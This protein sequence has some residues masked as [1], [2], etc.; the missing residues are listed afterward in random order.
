MTDLFQNVLTASFHGSIVI[1][2]VLLLRFLL[3]RTPKKFLC[4]LWLLVG[5][6]LLMPFEIQS[7]LS[8]QPDMGAIRE[9]GIVEAVPEEFYLDDMPVFLPEEPAF[10]E[11]EPQFVNSVA[12]PEDGAFAEEITAGEIRDN[13]GTS[14][15]VLDAVAANIWLAVAFGFGLYTFASYLKLRWKV[16]EAVRLKGNVWECDRIETAFILGFIRPRIYLPMG[17]SRNNRRHILAHERTHLEKG[18]HWIKMIGYAALAIHWFNPLVWVA[19]ILLCKDIEMACDE[20]VVQFMELEER[21]SYSAALINCSTNHAHFGAC[22]VAFGEVSVKNRVMTVLKYK[23]PSFWIS[24]A[25]VIAIIFVAVCLVTSPTEE[26]AV[27]DSTEPTGATEKALEET[28]DAVK[29]VENAFAAILAQDRYHLFFS[30]ETSD[31]SVGWQVNMYKDGENTLWSCTDH[32]TREGHMVLD[33]VHYKFIDGA[34]GG[35]VPYEEE[36]TMLQE[37]LAHFDLEGRDIQNVASHLNTRED[38]YT[39][40]SLTF[41]AYT[42]GGGTMPTSQPMTVY[43]DTEGSMTGMRVENPDRKGADIFSFSNWS[44]ENADINNIDDVFRNAR[45]NLLSAEDV[46]PSKLQPLTQDEQKMKEWGITF[47]VDDDVLTRNGGESWFAQASGYNMPVYTDNEYWLEKQTDTGWEKLEMLTQPKWEEASYTLNHDRY[48]VVKVDWTMLYGPLISGKY[49]MGKTFTM[50]DAVTSCIG[51]A[52]FDIYYNESNSADQKAAVERC[53]AGLEEL[54]QRD[55]IHY[56]ATSESFSTTEVWWNDGDYLCEGK[57]F[58]TGATGVVQGA[59]GQIQPR[60]DTMVRVDGVGYHEAR[61]NPDDLSSK[62]IG[63]ELS[64]FSPNRAGWEL[65][66]FTECLELMFFE[67]S[68]KTIT[69][70]DGIGVVSDEMVRFKQ[71]WPVQG[72]EV[73]E[74]SAQLTYK[75]DKNGNLYYMEYRTDD[76]MEPISIEVFDTTAAE[77]DARIKPYTENLVVDS[78]SW[79]DAKAKYTDAEFNIREDGFVNT[80]VNP[81]TGPVDAAKL[82]LKEYPNLGEYLS[83]DVFH[84]EAAGM[85]KVTIDSYVEYQS[86]HGYR[87]VYIA[88]N[89]MTC[90]LVYEGPI[91]YDEQ[92]K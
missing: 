27:V 17:M 90:L 10:S 36:D 68:N 19:Y 62:V 6:R 81:I 65:A 72:M 79:S 58:W 15:L 28:M 50:V 64:T 55:Y 38:G 51:Y 52:E 92:R 1:L 54:K 89:G 47:L 43:F 69:F 24:L 73:S 46:H 45:E 22:P 87:D 83:V 16:R 8:L 60:I 30:D 78:F 5:I 39:Y 26:A 56:L 11:N 77:I 67:R 49:R 57:F 7:G 61:E 25:G 88:D 23:K 33:G 14:M 59:D 53:Y 84:D 34:D 12:E 75:F 2:A 82:A 76:M 13:E 41:T 3:K 29:R 48:T 85:W 35:W 74:Y 71:T 44:T 63:M 42:D 70:P 20:R 37:M 32:M 9:T 18:D 40:E 31:G 21:K 86:T 80:Q 4:F 91:S 66:K